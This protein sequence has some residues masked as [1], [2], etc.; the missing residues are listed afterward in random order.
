MY[1]C[2]FV[3]GVYSMERFIRQVVCKFEQKINCFM[4]VRVKGGFKTKM[5]WDGENLFLNNPIH[6]NTLYILQ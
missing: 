6:Q 5:S 1:R 3:Q 2:K 4:N